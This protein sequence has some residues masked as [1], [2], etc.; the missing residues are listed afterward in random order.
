V[1]ICPSYVPPPSS[2]TYVEEELGPLSKIF[3][4][5]RFSY[6]WIVGV[7]YECQG[8]PEG[9]EMEYE[10]GIIT[11]SVKEA[12]ESKSEGK[13]KVIFVNGLFIILFY[14]GWIGR[15]CDHLV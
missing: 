3:V 12:S 10:T 6:F 4:G 14:F 7:G 11:G 13:Q 15:Y 9:L 1:R 2:K 5:C 8:L